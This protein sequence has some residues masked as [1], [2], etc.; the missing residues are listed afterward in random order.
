MIRRLA[1]LPL[2][3]AIALLVPPATAQESS[4]R[5]S[6]MLL[7]EVELLMPNLGRDLDPAQ[8]SC[9][10]L[11]QVYFILTDSFELRLDG[12]RQTI[13]AVFRREG[14]TR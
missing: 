7:A 14:L 11:A 6:P 1:P 13:I 2:A 12:Q 3:L 10:G 5:C 4:A 9:N 8:L